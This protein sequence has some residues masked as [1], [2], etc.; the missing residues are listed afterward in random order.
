MS[1]FFRI[2]LKKF[3]SWAAPMQEYEARDLHIRFIFGSF[4]KVPV[5]KKIAETEKPNFQYDLAAVWENY[6][7]HPR[8]TSAHTLSLWGWELGGACVCGANWSDNE[9]KRFADGMGRCSQGGTRLFGQQAVM[10][11]WDISG[12]TNL[13]HRSVMSLVLIGRKCVRKVFSDLIM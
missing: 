4:R 13:I 5:D 7:F 8:V 6:P 1:C 3:L 10:Q 12:C 2:F 9:E 11:W